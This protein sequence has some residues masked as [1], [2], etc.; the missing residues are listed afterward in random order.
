M[1]EPTT[2]ELIKALQPFARFGYFA[3]YTEVPANLEIYAVQAGDE[4]VAISAGDLALAHRL[5]WRFW[6]VQHGEPSSPVWLVDGEI[7]DDNRK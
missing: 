2:W 6:D 7:V 5:W 1:E 3:D 4:R